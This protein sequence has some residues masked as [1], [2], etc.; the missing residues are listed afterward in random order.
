M[1][2]DFNFNSVLARVRADLEH[3]LED[4]DDVLAQR[5]AALQNMEDVFALFEDLTRQRDRLYAAYIYLR[6]ALPALATLAVLGVR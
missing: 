6:D 2:P 4:R 5:A 3:L 1:M